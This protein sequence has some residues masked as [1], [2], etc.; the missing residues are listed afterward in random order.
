[1]L[2]L[3]SDESLFVPLEPLGERVPRARVQIR[4]DECK[5][6]KVVEERLERRSRVDGFESGEQPE[7]M[8]KIE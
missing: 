3:R 4:R 7:R 8:G 6:K 1:V 2:L 5:G